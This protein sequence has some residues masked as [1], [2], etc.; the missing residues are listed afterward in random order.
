MAEV[1]TL[2]SPLESRGR[3]VTLRLKPGEEVLQSLQDFVTA[4]G[5]GAVAIVTVV[6]SLTRAFIRYANQPQGALRE[7]HFEICSMTGTIEAA[8]GGGAH[9][10]IALS[11]G[12][13]AMFGGHMLPGC[14]VYTTAE[15]VLLILDDV[16]FSREDCPAS[17]YPELVITQGKN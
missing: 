9:V 11:D 10:H 12:K 15:V 14:R 16:A 8:G 2:Q 17:G 13:G 5:Y 3:F 4:Q 6:G 7:G 1:S